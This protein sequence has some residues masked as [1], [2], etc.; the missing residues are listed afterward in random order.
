[1]TLQTFSEKGEV[2]KTEL[3]VTENISR[4]GATV[5]TTLDVP[6]GRF[7]RLTSAEFNLMVHAVVRAR[8]KSA[9]GM[10]RIHVEFIDREWP[11]D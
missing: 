4:K 7:V 8:S 6:I 2:E 10:P 11:V 5:F 3:T 1:M 9:G